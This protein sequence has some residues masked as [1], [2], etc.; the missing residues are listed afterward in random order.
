VTSA[1][2]GIASL[3]GSQRLGVTGFDAQW[4]RSEKDESR[5]D[6]VDGVNRWV[7]AVTSVLGPAVL[8]ALQ[9]SNTLDV[10]RYREGAGSDRTCDA[11]GMPA[12]VWINLAITLAAILA[13]L[14]L[15]L[16]RSRLPK[17]EAAPEP[18][19]KTVLGFT[20]TFVGWS[21]IVGPLLPTGTG[22]SAL[23]EHVVVALT[24]T[25]TVALAAASWFGRGPART[26]RLPGRRTAR[27]R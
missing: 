19:A 24:A 4:A 9:F 17:W 15:A 16:F 13:V 23:I 14:G 18:I 22:T 1:P 11:L 3:W 20:I 21:S 5:F 26:G 6:G 8:L 27:H 7:L 12:G 2:S 10:E 25:L